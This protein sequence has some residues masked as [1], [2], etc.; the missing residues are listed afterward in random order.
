[1][2]TTSHPTLQHPHTPTPSPWQQEY[3]NENHDN[4]AYHSRPSGYH[5]VRTGGHSTAGRGGSQALP[6]DE[7]LKYKNN[8]KQK[9]TNTNRTSAE[10]EVSR[11]TTTLIHPLKNGVERTKSFVFSSTVPNKIKKRPSLASTDTT[12]STSGN[13]SGKRLKTN[14]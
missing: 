9:E 2:N 10:I 13:R 1:M 7:S 11:Q 5:Q 8:K 6:D 4:R 14:T 12:E 3:Q